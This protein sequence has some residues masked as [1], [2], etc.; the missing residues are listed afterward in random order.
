MK[1]FFL[2]QCLGIV[3]NNAACLSLIL[4]MAN[5]MERQ[6]AEKTKMIFKRFASLNVSIYW[7]DSAVLPGQVFSSTE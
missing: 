4:H 2:T 3:G 6:G 1:F 5:V 7:D